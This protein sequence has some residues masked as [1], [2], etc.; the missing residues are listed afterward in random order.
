MNWKLKS[1]IQ[2]A[3]ASLPY[4]GQGAY[5]WIQRNLGRLR[6]NW[7]CTFL[8]SEA[9][10]LARKLNSAG[11]PVADAVLMEVGTGRGL[12]MPVGYFLCGCREIHTFDLHRLLKEHV[13]SDLL[14][15]VRRHEQQVREIFADAATPAVFEPRLAALRQVHNL[16]ELCSVAAIRYHA[17]AD[18]ARTQLPVA[19]VDIQTSYTVFEHI[20]AEVLT[21]ILREATRILKPTGVAM[22]HIDLSD[23]FAHA[24]PSIPLVNFLRFPATEWER[25]GHNSFAYHNRLREP[26]YSEIYRQAGHEI[27]NWQQGVDAR[28]LEMLRN[29]FPI[30]EEFRHFSP[31]TLAISLLQVLSR[32]AAASC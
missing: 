15:Y 6:G 17:P 26:A 16:D 30:A 23:H 24:D 8:L 21:A 12:D 28:S 3:C 11:H 4:G 20:P 2:R 18:A 32:P 14:M 29:G 25:Y 10:K 7:D 19:S 13:V 31:E 9:A 5:Y 1:A 27:L 22:H